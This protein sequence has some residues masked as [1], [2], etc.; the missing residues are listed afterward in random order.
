MPPS[1]GPGRRPHQPTLR[2]R[3]ETTSRPLL[4]HLHALPRLIVPVGT[5][6]LIAIGAFAP[7]PYALVGFAIAFL[8]IAWVAYLA[9]PAVTWSGRLLR[10]AMLA[11]LVALAAVQFR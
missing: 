5:L 2:S 9:W 7:M 1:S 6:V 8:F 4:L 10:L 11:L 3:V